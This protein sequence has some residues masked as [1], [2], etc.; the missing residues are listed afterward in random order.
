MLIF[1]PKRE[2]FHLKIS[3]DRFTPN[4][5]K[6]DFLNDFQ[7]QWLK[8]AKRIPR[9]QVSYNQLFSQILIVWTHFKQGEENQAYFDAKIQIRMF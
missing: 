3:V 6:W 7:T 9:A 2:M 1:G 8:P 4:A 5:L